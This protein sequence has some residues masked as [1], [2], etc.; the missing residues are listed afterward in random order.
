[1]SLHTTLLPLLMSN[2]HR[3]PSAACAKSPLRNITTQDE[4]PPVQPV[5][6]SRSTTRPSLGRSTQRVSKI[7]AIFTALGSP[8]PVELLPHASK[9]SPSLSYQAS[10]SPSPPEA[11][12]EAATYFDQTPS[13]GAA[14]KSAFSP[15]S[16]ETESDVKIPPPE[17]WTIDEVVYSTPAGRGDQ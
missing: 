11:R 15:S 3:A 1:M 2:S 17:S 13:P 6:R 9:R 16:E 8:E 10:S 5:A 7:N 12:K 14:A 4:Q